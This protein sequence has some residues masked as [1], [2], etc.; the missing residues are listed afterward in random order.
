MS[1]T[2]IIQIDTASSVAIYEQI[3]NAIRAHLVAGRL[4][5]GAL[6]PP[7]REL[8]LNL[9]VHHNTVAEAY[10]TLAR[11]G[12]L[13]LR[14]KRGAVVLARE[15]PHATAAAERRFTRHLGELTAKALADG[16]SPATA[17]RHLEAIAARL[18]NG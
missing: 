3:A 12:W 1:D 15:A 7:V 2:S 16:V 10:R 4:Q 14:R 17:A 18:R 5:P 9:G 13:D 6:L 11:E 8:A